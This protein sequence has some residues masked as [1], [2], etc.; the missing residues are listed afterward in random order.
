MNSHAAPANLS[1]AIALVRTRSL[2]VVKTGQNTGLNAK[3]ATYT[4][5]LAVLNPVLQEAGLAVG[6]RPG[7][8]R[9]EGTGDKTAWVQ[10]LLMEVSFSGTDIHME[11]IEFE[12]LFPE[13]NRG[14]NLTQRQGMAHT[15]GKRYALVDYF[16]MITGDDDDAERLGQP[17]SDTA[18]KADKSAHWRQFCYVPLFKVG[19]EEIAGTWGTLANP[20]DATGETSLGDLAPGK[21]STIWQRF[22]DD[23]GINAWRAELTGERAAGKGYRTWEECRSNHKTLNLPE[24]FVDCTGQ[25]LTNLALALK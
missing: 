24:V 3:Y 15:Y 9:L 17:L 6:F 14:T 20:A 23:A 21:L 5:V 10:S 18:P 2:V 1:D 25:Q 7:K 8:V 13:G 19:S 11:K 22:P 12:V 16:G 4:D